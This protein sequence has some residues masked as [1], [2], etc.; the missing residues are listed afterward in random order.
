MSDLT[1]QREFTDVIKLKVLRWEDYLGLSGYEQWHHKG[2]FKREV[3][4][5]KSEER[6]C[7]NG[8]GG[9]RDAVAKRAW[10][11]VSL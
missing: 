11:V 10:K 3:G 2:P 5:P 4:E 6:G 7:D 1:W 9:Q 8:S